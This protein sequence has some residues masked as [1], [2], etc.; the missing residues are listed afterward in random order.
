MR[1]GRI[2]E[3]EEV[4]MK[5]FELLGHET[6]MVTT[7]VSWANLYQSL[8]HVREDLDGKPVA[9]GSGGAAHQCKSPNRLWGAL[10]EDKER[11]EQQGKSHADLKP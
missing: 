10:H 2:S 3:G 8:E 1:S 9:S 5:G 11:R 7:G 6:G 4:A